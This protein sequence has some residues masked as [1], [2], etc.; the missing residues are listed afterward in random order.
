MSRKKNHGFNQTL[1]DKLDAFETLVSQP[2]QPAAVVA[3]NV[4]NFGRYFFLQHGAPGPEKFEMF[5]NLVGQRWV[6]SYEG[7]WSNLAAR[8][9]ATQL[10]QSLEGQEFARWLAVTDLSMA[11]GDHAEYLN[12]VPWFAPL[13]A[14][15]LMIDLAIR[16]VD[17]KTTLEDCNGHVS[18]RDLHCWIPASD[19]APVVDVRSA[20]EAYPVTHETLSELQVWASNS[21]F[22]GLESFISPHVLDTKDLLVERIRSATTDLARN[23]TVSDFAVFERTAGQVFVTLQRRG[24]LSRNAFF[25]QATKRGLDHE[26]S[27]R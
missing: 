10:A 16:Y 2:V 3:A 15:S 17:R 13:T 4:P 27:W 7:Y 20:N 11:I 24:R 6:T 23:S 22:R 9:R 25:L 14:E 19:R 21:L 8:H 5:C 26:R 1:G 18:Q 12:Q